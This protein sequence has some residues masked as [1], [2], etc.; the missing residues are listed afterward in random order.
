MKANGKRILSILLS[1]CLAAGLLAVMPIIAS[2]DDFPYEIDGN[3]SVATIQAGIQAEIDDAEEGDTITVTGEKTDADADLTLSIPAGVTVIWEAIYTG[4]GVTTGLIN[5][6]GAGTFEVA[7]GA[8]LEDTGGEPALYTASTPILVSGGSVMA[9]NYPIYSGSAIVTV[10]GGTVGGEGSAYGIV[11]YSGSVIVS[12]GDVYGDNTAIGCDN[13]AV[14]VSDGSVI[15]GNIAIS[16]LGSVTVSGGVVTGDAFAVNAAGN[17]TVS[18]GTVTGSDLAINAG[19]NVAVSGGIVTAPRCAVVAVGNAAISGEADVQATGATSIAIICAGATV[20]G[21][22]VKALGGESGTCALFAGSGNV[23]VSGGTVEAA[24]GVAILANG[25]TIGTVP[26][27]VTVSGDALVTGGPAAITTAGGL[28]DVVVSGG[29][30][31]A[32]AGE[33]I[34]ISTNAGKVTVSG[35]S[36]DGFM[37][38][39]TVSGAVAVSGGDVTGEFIAIMSISGA[40]TVSGGGTVTAAGIEVELEPEPEEEEGATILVGG[41][42]IGTDSGNIT[43]SGGTV[44][45]AGE[46]GVALTTGS[47]IIVVTGGSVAA[48]VAIWIDDYGVAAYYA[49]TC[50]GDF[51]VDDDAGL[52]Y[53]VAYAYDAALLG[54]LH[55]TANG[56]T[57]KA[58]LTEAKWNF[59]N[60]KSLID[61]TLG[62]AAVKS[63]P[64]G[65]FTGPALSDGNIDRTSD[66]ASTIGLTTNVSGKLY[67][68]VTGASALAPTAQQVLLGAMPP[69]PLVVDAGVLTDISVVLTPGARNIYLV[70]EDAAGNLSNVLLISALS[71]QTRYAVTVNF[72]TAGAATYPAGVNARVTAGTPPE[73]KVFDKW[74]TAD[75]EVIFENAN[76]A[77]TTFIMPD[78]A[79]TVTATFKDAPDT[80]KY[81][82]FRLFNCYTKY[83]SNHWNWFKFVVLFGW[84]WMWFI[85]PVV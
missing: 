76:A 30:V 60:A 10:S 2:A 75:T 42:A 11:N 54:S 50:T 72:G 28:G 81:V 24:Q 66:T 29:T 84:I 68:V 9:I 61:F 34:A 23:A 5:L 51:E 55:G 12:G 20:S 39:L 70:L 59:A 63:V 74:T 8:E 41:V 16:T 40:V 57:K 48:D 79:V 56:L 62:N 18:S 69:F 77:S 21:G 58:G 37:A 73:G 53:E 85:P 13:A 1:L 83:I 26:V 19:G 45:S 22:S 38:I 25:T 46:E 49:G 65:T 32:T 64:W 43:V 36:V 31:T 82:G 33:S 47:G 15:G 14:T 78:K 71:Y 52:I 27:S 4:A 17:V 67:C 44:T 7:E 3:D 80:T 35:G 6:L